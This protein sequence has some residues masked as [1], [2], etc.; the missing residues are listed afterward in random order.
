MRK[1][2]Q[3]ILFTA[4]ATLSV[5]LG[6]TGCME[7]KEPTVSSTT[8]EVAEVPDTRKLASEL[9][10]VIPTH[11]EN[12]FSEEVQTKLA[13]SIQ[14]KLADTKYTLEKPLVYY[15]PFGTNLRSANIYFTTET[16]SKI[17]YTIHVEQDN[18]PDYSQK[19]YINSET[20]FTKEHSYQLIGLIPN[21]ENTISL[22]AY[23]QDGKTTTSTF[24]IQVP[25][26]NTAGEL[27]LDVTTKKEEPLTNGLFCV[28]YGRL[29]KDDG[30]I[31]NIDL[32][33]NDGILRSE[34]VVDSYRTDNIQFIDN[35]IFYCID[36]QHLAK[37]NA[38]GQIVRI[39]DLGQ[40]EFHHDLVYNEEQNHFLILVNDTKQNTVE[41]MIIS[42]NLE[43]GEVKEVLDL[44]DVL[45]EAYKKGTLPEDKEK[46]DWAHINAIQLI[47]NT[48]VVLSFRELSSIVKVDHI[49]TEP[50]LTYIL[51]ETNVW[52]DTSYE[53]YVYKKI[54]DFTAQAGQHAIT[55]VAGESEDEYSLFLFNN[56]F[57]YSATRPEI[58]WSNYTL[59]QG[60][61][62]DKNSY[63]YEYKI[64]ETEKTFELVESFPVPYSQYVSNIQKLDNHYIVCPGMQNMFLEYDQNG[65]V[66]KEF[67]QQKSTIIYRTIKYDF[68]DFWFSE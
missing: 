11:S 34:L 55:Y 1:N 22:T 28:F 21:A 63:Y 6:T 62:E 9:E 49:Y 4:F 60:K 7:T 61:K 52:E 29:T 33:D 64:N 39:Y 20:E 58:D 15:N 36:E 25:E 45:P 56:N 12:I 37:V 16:P 2:I 42:L 27:I 46:L 13:N 41:D 19:L 50:T 5:I 66:I 65:E 26:V 30:Q 17:E 18:I 32:Y 44:K 51:C 68:T 59:A 10:Y 57:T 54:G 67:K 47:D 8:E 53:P 23:D 40:Y 31:L 43:S 14:E 24:Q 38:L 35:H 3:K 48:D